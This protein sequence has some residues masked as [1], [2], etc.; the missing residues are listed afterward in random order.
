VVE[1]DAD[2]DADRDADR[3]E[4]RDT[5]KGAAAAPTPEKPGRY[6][7]SVAGGVGSLVVL[8]VAVLAFVAF[9]AGFRENDQTDAQ[10]IDYLAVVAPAQQ[11]GVRLVYPPA[12]PKGWIASSV[13]YLPGDRPAWGL[14]MLTAGGKFVGLRQQDEDVSTLLQT[15]VDAN[16][17]EGQ[18]IDVTGSVASQWQEWSDSGG[19]HAYS[20]S[21][22]GDEV[23]VWGDAPT[24][25]L[26][27]VVRSLTDARVKT[28][29]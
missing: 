14:G 29:R 25:D 28:A 18:L 17:V 22:G 7:R 15:Y 16:P 24:E 12:L 4:D 6:Q 11:A 1:Q 13:S 26:L 21:V 10:P 9:R 2:Q 23:L 19:D 3:D 27:T 20:A 5:A 8:V